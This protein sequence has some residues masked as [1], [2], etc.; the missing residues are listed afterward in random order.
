MWLGGVIMRAE[1]RAYEIQSEDGIPVTLPSGA[2][3]F[4]L[5]DTEEHY[6][7][8]KI[9]RYM[10]DNHFVNVS[11]ILEIDRMVTFELLIH[12]WTLWLSRGK[13]YWNNTINSKQ[14]SDTVQEFSREIRQ[15]K[16]G[17]G[18]DKTSRDR[19]RGDDSMAAHWDNLLQRAREFG[20]LRNE[21]FTQV[22]TSFQRIKAIVQFHL[23][24]DEIERKENACELPDVLEVIQEEISKFDQID[25]TFRFEKQRMWIRNQ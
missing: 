11:D 19:T 3:Y 23:N 8:D 5:T 7:R 17:L 25:E 9:G 21:Q 14:L 4:V 24:S 6:L 22:I 13:D 1:P 15:L 16:K 18:V 2:T 12:R 10:S 20:Y